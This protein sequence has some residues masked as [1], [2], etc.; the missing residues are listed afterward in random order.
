M[1]TNE[2]N[3]Q[4]FQS[5]VIL[6]SWIWAGPVTRFWLMTAEVRHERPYWLALLGYSSRDNP[7]SELEKTN[8]YGGV[9][10]EKM[11]CS[12]QNLNRAG[13]DINSHTDLPSQLLSDGKHMR[14]WVSPSKQPQHTALWERII[15]RCLRH[16]VWGG[17]LKAIDNK[18]KFILQPHLGKVSDKHMTIWYR[19]TAILWL[20][21]PETMSS[22]RE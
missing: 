14:S 11:R 18:N 5:L 4:H 9:P 6:S 8:L 1:A 13:T 2:L 10:R 12:S 7:P 21:E 20:I 15:N 16:W 19:N 17:L 3:S 22:F